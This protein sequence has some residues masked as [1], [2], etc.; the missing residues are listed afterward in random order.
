MTAQRDLKNIIRERQ[1]K[2]GEAYTT[3]KTALR[4]ARRGRFWSASWQRRTRFQ[5]Q[6]RSQFWVVAG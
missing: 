1:R 6:I 3:G 4:E 2:T 5:E